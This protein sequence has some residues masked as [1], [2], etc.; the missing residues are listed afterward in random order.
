MRPPLYWERMKF[1]ENFVRNWKQMYRG[2]LTL[3]IAM[4][5]F[6]VLYT[7]YN[8]HSASPLQCAR[9]GPPSHSG[10]PAA[11]SPRWNLLFL[12]THKTGS[13]TILNI[14]LRFAERRGLSVALPAGGRHDFAY[15]NPFSHRAVAGFTPDSCFNLVAS[16]MRFEP[17]EVSRLQP[18]ERVY[19]TILRHPARLFESSFR[20]FGPSVPLTWVI[21][22]PNKMAT[23]LRHPWT[24]YRPNAYN[25]HYLRNLQFF[26]LG[27]NKDMDP[28]HSALPGIFRALEDHFPL[29]MLTE[30][31]DES[32]VLLKELLC[33][34][35]DD[36]VYFRLNARDPDDRPPLD[37]ALEELALSWNELD[38]LLYAHFNRTFWRKVEAFGRRRMAWEVAQLRWANSKMAEACLEGRG[39][40][41]AGLVREA[42]LKPWQPA[43]GRGNILGYNLRPDIEEAHRDLCVAMLT[44]EMQYLSRMGASL[45]R[46][47]AWSALRGIL[48]L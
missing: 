1:Q 42:S 9:P 23:F 31:F 32:M 20:Y 40:V 29:V 38:S 18:P 7:M 45:W 48:G 11:C 39:P 35:L 30:Y 2:L 5:L 12:K 10:T 26:D 34:E 13:S 21:P 16:H 41:R 46:V 3:V 24:Y 33:W 8:D 44:P 36:V 43:G 22:G 19:F 27:Y 4:F 47:K 37:P 25:A 14:L 15:P 28:N 6:I 17:G